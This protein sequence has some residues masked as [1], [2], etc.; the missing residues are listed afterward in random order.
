MKWPAD[1]DMAERGGGRWLRLRRVAIAECALQHLDVPWAR[2]ELENPKI[3]YSVP[4]DSE[5]YAIRQQAIQIAALAVLADKHADDDD[6]WTSH[7]A[8]QALE[9]PHADHVEDLFHG[10]AAVAKMDYSFRERLLREAQRLA[11]EK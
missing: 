7:F 6:R 8:R 10:A 5:W 3:G 1:S 9:R 4:E 11:D 2:A